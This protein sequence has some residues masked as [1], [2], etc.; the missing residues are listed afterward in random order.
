MKTNNGEK[1]YSEKFGAFVDDLAFDDVPK[2]VIDKAKLH[3]LDTLGVAMATYKS[4]Y[5]E[6]ML[7]VCKSMGGSPESTAI[8]SGGRKSVANAALVNGTMAHG[9]DCDDFHRG[10]SL[11]LST[12]VVPT[13]LAVSEATGSS[14]KNALVAAVAGYEMGARLGLAASRKFLMQ[15][16]HPTGV[17]GAFVSAAITGKILGLTGEQIAS[18]IGIAG[19]QSSGSAQFMEEGSW[20][21]RMH[22]GWAS[23]SGII[24]GLL[25]QKGYDGPHR[26]FEGGKGVYVGYLGEGGFDPEKLHQGLGSTWEVEQISYKFYPAGF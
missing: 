2:H 19:S 16:W 17:L 20:T 23:H 21:K 9:L 12:F 13:A 5:A 14:G 18:A 24:A 25:A 7:D 15:G 10:A 6:I 3:I 8:G 4:P 11:H 26:I 1:T 22:P